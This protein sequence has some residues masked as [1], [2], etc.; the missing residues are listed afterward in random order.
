M[1]DHMLT[2]DTHKSCYLYNKAA[3]V[4]GRAAEGRKTFSLLN[5]NSCSINKIEQMVQVRL[6]PHSPICNEYEV[7]QAVND[8]GSLAL[9]NNTR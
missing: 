3:C 2:K 9:L 8:H 4:S 6:D 1:T 5:S 7:A